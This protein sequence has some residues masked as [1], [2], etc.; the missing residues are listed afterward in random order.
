MHSL[1][2]SP[3]QLN[4]LT[5]DVH[6]YSAASPQ[7]QQA[8]DPVIKHLGRLVP[9]FSGVDRFAG[10]LTGVHFIH[11]T[12][13]RFQQVFRTAESFP[14]SVFTLHML[15]QPTSLLP[16]S[17]RRNLQFQIPAHACKLNKGRSYYVPLLDRFFRR[18]S[19]LYPILAPKQFY[20]GYQ[21]I[22][23][24]VESG[25]PRFFGEDLC[26]LN[27]IYLVLAVDAWDGTDAND[28]SASSAEFY[29]EAATEVQSQAIERGDMSSLQSLLLSSLFLQLSGQH[30]LLVQIGGM[31]IRLAQSLGLHRHT[32]RFKLCAGMLEMRNRLWWCAYILD[33]YAMLPTA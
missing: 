18:W 7:T 6:H 12:E 14:E 10:S 5:K 24:A 11:S 23:D 30:A 3:R 19:L 13:Q 31:A 26:T 16:Q 21:R 1:P 15:P 32:R 25:T 28:V 29:F 2:I 22:M 9:T 27:H 8:P 17:G 20:Y 33:M 4:P